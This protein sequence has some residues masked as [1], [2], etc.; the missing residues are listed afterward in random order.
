M[1]G[2]AN[3]DALAVYCLVQSDFGRA[4]DGLPLEYGGR[5]L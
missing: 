3:H 5:Q 1:L 2:D 4:S